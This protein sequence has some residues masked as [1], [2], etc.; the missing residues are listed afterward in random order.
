M[1]HSGFAIPLMTGAYKDGAVHRYLG[2]TSILEN[3]NPE[4]IIQGIFGDSFSTGN[5]RRHIIVGD[6]KNG[7]DTDQ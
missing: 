5:L 3:Q 2:L 7:K 4:S 1:G 6:T